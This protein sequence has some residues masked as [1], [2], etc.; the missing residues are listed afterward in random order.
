MSYPYRSRFNEDVLL[1]MLKLVND[2]EK[3]I[4]ESL[5][6]KKVLDIGCNDGSLLGLFKDKGAITVGI[7]PTDTYIDALGGKMFLQLWLN[8]S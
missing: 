4:G 1:G 8:K 3:K 7:E 5:K 6:D 2:C